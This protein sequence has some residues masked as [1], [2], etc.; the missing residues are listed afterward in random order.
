MAATIRIGT[1]SWADEGLLREWY[2][3][4]V[5][6]GE[7]RL[8]YYAERFD[9]VEV[10]STFYRLPAPE[11]TARWAERTPPGFT[12]HVKASGELTGHRDGA[13]VEVEAGRLRE[14]LAPLEASGK[15][16]GVLLQYHP[17]V[18]KTAAALR[19]LAAM[20]ELLTP[21]VPLV[22]FRHRS[23]LEPGEATSTLAF[24]RRHGLAFV[25]VDT[26]DVA[27]ANV[28]PRLAAATHPVAYV[29]FHGR[30]AGT[31]NVRGARA[32]WERF[33]WRYRREEL[34]EWVEPLRGLAGEA[35]EVYALLNVNRGDQAPRSASLLRGLLDE[36]G[37]AATGAQDV[38][39]ATLF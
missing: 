6:S 26:P 4:D 27:A 7:A 2:P 33:D 22:E 18:T 38:A 19:A 9:V 1:C 24:L 11:T 14:S 8:R 30:N 13:G 21:L 10:D 29:R 36:A 35:E 12:F 39:P 15:L 20:P 28:V 31:W 3:R 32:S 17:R 34:A 25:S 37:L 5:S 16:R 23:W